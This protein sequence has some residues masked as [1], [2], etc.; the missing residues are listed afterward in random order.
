[1]G[2]LGKLKEKAAGLFGRRGRKAESTGM[3]AAQPAGPAVEPK[4]GDA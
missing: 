2:F 3:E 4:A 1:M